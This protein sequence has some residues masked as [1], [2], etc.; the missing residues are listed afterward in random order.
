MPLL[1]VKPISLAMLVSLSKSHFLILTMSTIHLPF[2]SFHTVLGGMRPDIK[3]E[4]P[5]ELQQ[6]LHTSFDASPAKR[7]TM[8]LVFDALRSALY[9]ARGGHTSKLKKSHLL[10]SRSMESLMNCENEISGN[11]SI[12]M[13]IGNKLR[14]SFARIGRRSTM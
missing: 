8:V 12:N 11:R 7:P 1:E 2:C 4:W 10:R 13:N 6:L 3:P 5:S 9:Q 14:E